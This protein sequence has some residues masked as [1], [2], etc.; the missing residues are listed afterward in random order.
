MSGSALVALGD[1]QVELRRRRFALT[2][3][4][5]ALTIPATYY[6]GVAL[7]RWGEPSDL[8]QHLAALHRVPG[9]VG[10]WRFVAE[11]TPLSQ[12]VVEQ[13][14]LRGHLHRVYEHPATG[15]RVSLLLLLGPAGPLVRHPPEICYESSANS[16]L[17]SHSL[18]VDVDGTPQQLRLLAYRSESM[19]DGDFL[20]A[21]GFGADR[22]WDCP[23]SPRRVYGGR[24]ILYK[25]QVLTDA[26]AEASVTD[27]EGLR[28]FLRHMLSALNAAL[29]APSST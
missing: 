29:P 5:F 1:S 2:L 18:T 6:S 20:V 15:Q 26:A 21:Y 13:L 8:S 19:I 25:L 17:G 16:L 23:A 27:P 28:D 3:A 12:A 24:P 9:Q 22:E 14:Q 10:Q 4:V 7:L 11:G